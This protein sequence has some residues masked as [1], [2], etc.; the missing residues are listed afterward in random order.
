MP[1]QVRHDI[2]TCFQQGGGGAAEAVPS[3]PLPQMWILSCR[4]C[5]GIYSTVFVGWKKSTLPKGGVDILQ[6]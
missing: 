1:K 4:T 5:F 6:T 3:S 2:G